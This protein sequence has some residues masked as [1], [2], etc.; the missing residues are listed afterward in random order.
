M[1]PIVVF[2][3]CLVVAVV[4]FYWMVLRNA[5]RSI[6]AQYRQLAQTHGLEL[7]EPTPVMGG[8]IR[9]EPSLYGTYSGREISLSVPGKGLQGT[10]Q[11]E[12]VLKVELRDPRFA[13]QV[14]A[15]GLLGGFRQRDSR[16]ME[17]WKSGDEAFDAAW[18]VR[19]SV[20]GRVAAAFGPELRQRMAELLRSGKGSLYIGEGVMAYAELGL[21][22]K[23]ATRQRFEQMI[24]FLCELGETI[25]STPGLKA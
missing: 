8:F 5:S 23:P 3:L 7:T 14:A 18:D 9:P 16:G 19:T 1:S 11:I 22:S 2:I 20:P 13:A 10:R 12:T 25:E 4:V 24:G 17:R 6:G 21:I 15:S